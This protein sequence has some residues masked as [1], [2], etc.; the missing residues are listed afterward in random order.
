MPVVSD[1]KQLESTVFHNNLNRGR[2]GIN[3]ILDEL[4]ESVHRCY[5]D[6][7]C[8]DLIYNILIKCLEVLISLARNSNSHDVP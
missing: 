7:A 6:L 8:G 4:F 2:A 1:L 3:S 5:D